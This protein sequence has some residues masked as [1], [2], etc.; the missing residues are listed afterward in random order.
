[1]LNYGKT[2]NP[3]KT[4]IQPSKYYLVA[5]LIILLG[6]FL[7]FFLLTNKS[8]W[9]DEG[10][11]L[12]YSQGSNAQ[13]VINRFFEADTGDRFQPFYYLVLYYWRQLFGNSEFA[14]RSLSAL[15]GVG[16][17]IVLFLTALQTYGKKHAI[18][19]VLFLS[20]SSYAIYYSQQTRAYALL[21]FLASLQLYFF[22]KALRTSQTSGKVSA[23]WMLL[24]CITTGVNLFFSILI[25]IFT[26]SIFLAHTI[27]YKNLKQWFKWWV[28]AALCCLPAIIFYLSS[29]VATTPT[30]VNVTPSK[31]PVIQNLIFVLYGLLVGETYGPPIEELRGGNRI[32]ILLSYLPHLSVLLVFA[33]ILFLAVIR[34]WWQN[35]LDQS[36]RQLDTFFILLFTLSL[37]LGAIFAIATKF[38]W[39]PRH[40]FYIYIPLVFLIPLA[41]RRPF[42][43]HKNSNFLWQLGQIAVIALIVINIYSVANY[44]FNRDYQREDY[45]VVAQYLVQHQ[46]PSVKSVLLYGS[47]NLLPYY[48]DTQTLY[49]LELDTSNLAQEVRKITNDASQVLIAISFQSFW[50]QKKNFSLERSMSELYNLESKTSF[51]NFHIYHFV[52]K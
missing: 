9:L 20:V 49:G 28:I 22:T 41:V 11:S 45:R 35:N 31:Q 43:S 51:T 24:F 12:Y 7:R 14:V 4:R 2:N 33:I 47:P 40:S 27:V 30:E 25:A 19:L 52:K 21:L 18:W 37:A 16:A 29:P 42:R 17:V 8:L 26:F 48:G 46:S 5:F 50:E 6:T 13:Q 39:L 32:Q 34:G 10:Y 15:S 44:Y 3:A 36:D 1:M 38:N 23:R